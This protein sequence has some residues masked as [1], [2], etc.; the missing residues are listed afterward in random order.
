MGHRA[1]GLDEYLE[2]GLRP[3]ELVIVGARP[4]HGQDGPRFD[5]RVHMAAT[6]PVAFLSME[7]SQTEVRDRLTAMLGN[8]PCR[9]SSARLEGDGLDWDRVSDGIEKA[10]ELR[11]RMMTRA[12]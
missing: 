8:V 10:K 9:R 12:A 4:S 5:H 2:G 6:H 3:G 1:C 7:M 11:L